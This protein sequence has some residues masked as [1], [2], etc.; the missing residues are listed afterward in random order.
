MTQ[1]IRARLSLVTLGVADVARATEFYRALGW[2]PSSASVPGEVTFFGLQGAILGLWRRENLA[3]EANVDAG[4]PGAMSSAINLETRAAV[5]AA[6][7][8]VRE[9]GGRVTTRPQATD[10][11]GYSGYFVDLDGHA[12]EIAHNPFWPIGADGRP[13]LP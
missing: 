10:W 13:E 5:D 1:P 11:G 3:A 6:F 2:E 12:W 8:R 9:A 4:R 7:E